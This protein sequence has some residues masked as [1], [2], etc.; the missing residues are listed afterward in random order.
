MTTF[1]IHIPKTSGTTLVHILSKDPRNHIGYF[2]PSRGEVYDFENTVK[3]RPYD[4]LRDNPD[5]EKKYNIIAGHFTFGV[6]EIFKAQSF[7]YISVVRHPLNHYIS[8][9]KAFLRMSAPYK[10]YL[11]PENKEKSIHAMLNKDFSHNLQTFFLSGLS[12]SEIKKDKSR[13]YHTT[14]ENIE[15]YFAGIC[16]TEKFD[17]GLFYLQ[18]KIGFKP[19]LYKKKNVATNNLPDSEL[20]SAATRILE[21]NDVDMKVYD[22]LS[23]KFN[24]EYSAINGISIKVA[25][26]KSLNLASNILSSSTTKL[27]NTI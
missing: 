25:L 11:V 19:Y 6:H 22:Y 23:R 14:I 24:K 10:D 13:A 1:F 4:H 20:K 17:E 5:W 9:Y 26:F 16:L 8:L 18:H 3:T 2:Y 27:F 12:L 7:R 21:V 15:K